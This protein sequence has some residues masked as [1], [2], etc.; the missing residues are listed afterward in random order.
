LDSS[1]KEKPV[2]EQPTLVYTTMY[3]LI[4]AIG[5]F[6]GGVGVPAL[7]NLALTGK[8]SVSPMVW[9]LATILAI[10]AFFNPG[11]PRKKEKQ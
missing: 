10:I 5:S 4:V 11:R 2:A 9:G 7:I 1:G 3:R 8:A 6:I